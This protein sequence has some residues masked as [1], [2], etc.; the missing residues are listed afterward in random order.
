MIFGAGGAARAIAVELAQEGAGH[1]TIVNR[2]PDRGESLVALLND[3]TKTS[4][5]FA[6]WQGNYSVP[7]G[8]D[9][10]VNA[11]NIGLAPNIVSQ[12]RCGHGLHQ[13]KHAGVRC[14]PQP[15]PH[16]FLIEATSKGA[17]T[18]DGLGMLVYQGAIAF[19]MWTGKD[20]PIAEM[21]QALSEIFV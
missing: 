1:I 13:P 5:T 17:T 7:S 6:L 20:A 18:L 4:S 11:T 12:A 9:I 15:T 16:R 10:V 2:T 14:D 8:T 21:K 3:K 19:T